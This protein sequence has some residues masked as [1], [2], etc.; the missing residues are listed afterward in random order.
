MKPN[1]KNLFIAAMVL[2]EFSISS[3]V[4]AQRTPFTPESCYEKYFPLALQI[5]A[6]SVPPEVRLYCAVPWDFAALESIKDAL[7]T[8]KYD[9]VGATLRTTSGTNRVLVSKTLPMAL[10]AADAG[11]PGLGATYRAYSML[12]LLYEIYSKT[13]DAKKWLATIDSND[14]VALTSAASAIKWDRPALA[15]DQLPAKSAILQQG[16]RLS[17][18]IK[19]IAVVRQNK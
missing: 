13:P 17:D 15:K 18:A 14:A 3:S 4:I 11:P 10:N 9:I 2:V 16:A 6:G 8:A 7:E 19:V 5:P 12:P 1:A